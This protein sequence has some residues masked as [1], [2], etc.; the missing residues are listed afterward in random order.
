MV[1]GGFGNRGVNGK[2]SAIQFARENKIPFFGICLG[3]Q[4]AVI[5]F[6][7][8]V[9]GLKNAHSLEFDPNSPNPVISLMAEQKSVMNKGATMRLGA[10]PCVIQKGTLAHKVYGEKEISERHRHRYEFNN[11]FKEKLTQ[12]GLIFSGT[13]PDGSL[14]EIIENKKHPFFIA[15]Q[16]HPEFQSKPMTPHPLFS[17]FVE[18]SIQYAASKEW[19]E[20]KDE[21]AGNSTLQQESF[22]EEEKVIS[23]KKIA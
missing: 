5:E 21:K 10:Y 20:M 1:P 13:S 14:V 7:R 12:K 2:I 23:W 16:F 17:H 18:A 9:A 22:S 4:L 8:N 15:C 6:A 11:T 3:M 19:K